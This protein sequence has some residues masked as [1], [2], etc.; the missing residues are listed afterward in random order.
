MF[1]NTATS[2]DNMF[3]RCV[4]VVRVGRRLRSPFFCTFLALR[5]YRPFEYVCSSVLS[6]SVLS[7]TL[8]IPTFRHGLTH[9]SAHWHQPLFLGL[10]RSV[11]HR[12][13]PRPLGEVR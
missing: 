10:A 9:D 13:M 5:P 11:A 6:S 7:L 4:R 3:V 8:H 12:P 1:L 2:N